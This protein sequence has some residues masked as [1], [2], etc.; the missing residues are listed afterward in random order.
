MEM[1]K[2]TFNESIPY[3]TAW[4]RE[5][6]KNKYGKEHM[7]EL[8]EED[9]PNALRVLDL[10]LDLR[11]INLAYIPFSEDYE[12]LRRR[13]KTPLMLK[14]RMLK[15]YERLRMEQVECHKNLIIEAFGDDQ[16]SW[17]RGKELRMILKRNG[18]DYL[19]TLLIMRRWRVE[20]LDGVGYRRYLTIAKGLNERYG[21]TAW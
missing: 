10:L 8:Y 9:V 2:A 4:H 17:I 1:I 12:K 19:R 20:D 15:M 16:L 18:I 6:M 11:R 3:I 7:S 21:I 14:L 13:R 5:W